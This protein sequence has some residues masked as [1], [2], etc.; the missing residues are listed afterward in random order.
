MGH[1]SKDYQAGIM[2]KKVPQLGGNSPNVSK[3]PAQ[4]GGNQPN[5]TRPPKQTNTGGNYTS[6]QKVP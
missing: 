2:G 5:V 6:G 1:P 3:P 4:E